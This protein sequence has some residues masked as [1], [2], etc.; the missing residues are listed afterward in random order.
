MCCL[1]FF[2][3]H[4]FFI[5]PFRSHTHTHTHTHTHGKTVLLL[6]FST[7]IFISPCKKKNQKKKTTFRH[8]HHLP[9]SLHLLT[10]ET[11]ITG[12]YQRRATWRGIRVWS[13]SSAY[14][15]AAVVTPPD[16]VLLM[17]TLLRAW[18]L[19]SD[20]IFQRASR[21]WQESCLLSVS[22]PPPSSHPSPP[23]NN[24]VKVF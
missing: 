9:A 21:P 13:F 24:P 17:E 6:I 16:L 12:N 10:D 7:P 3:F 19:Y 1:A 15:S 5:H 14:Q 8:Q 23:L 20:T 11:K 22:P 18:H 2:L 4:L